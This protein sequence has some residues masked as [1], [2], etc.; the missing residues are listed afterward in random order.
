MHGQGD[1][2]FKRDV[3]VFDVLAPKGQVGIAQL[4]APAVLGQHVDHA[5]VAR[6]VG[7]KAQIVVDDAVKPAI[8]LGFYLFDK[9]V[10]HLNVHRD[11]QNGEV[12]FL[13]GLGD[14]VGH[15]KTIKNK[16]MLI[17]F[18]KIWAI[19]VNSFTSFFNNQK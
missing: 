14:C 10:L 2:A 17:V 7:Q 6:G 19:Y 9:Q 3:A 11:A 8:A 15:I 16:Q 12:Q 4:Q 1:Q 18:V 13:E 5:G